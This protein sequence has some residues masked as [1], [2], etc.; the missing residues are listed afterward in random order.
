MANAIH[1]DNNVTVSLWVSST[2]NQN[3]LP[4]IITTTTMTLQ[5]EL[6][7]ASTYT[8]TIRNDAISDDSFVKTM[9]G[10]DSTDATKT[11]N[12]LIDPITWCLLCEA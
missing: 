6:W 9:Q 3:A 11:I 1:D 5:Y 12:I 4:I 10:T 7:S 8:T 2:N